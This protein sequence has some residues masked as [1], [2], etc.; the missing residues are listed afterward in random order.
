[1]DLIHRLELAFNRLERINKIQGLFFVLISSLLLADNLLE[2]GLDLWLII[3]SAILVIIGMLVTD[4][5]KPVNEIKEIIKQL[6][7]QT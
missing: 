3:A 7:A 1:M 6:N 4:R 5:Q 2:D